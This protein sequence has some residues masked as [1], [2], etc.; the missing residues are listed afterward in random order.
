MA[1]FDVAG[2]RIATLVDT[3][4]PAG[5]RIVPWEGKDEGGRSVASG[6]YFVRVRAGDY[7]TTMKMT[8]VR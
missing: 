4:L 7:Q 3:D 1:V 8:L 5:S 6:I 2:R